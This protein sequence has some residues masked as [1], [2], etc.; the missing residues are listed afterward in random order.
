MTGSMTIRHALGL[1]AATLALVAAA[2]AT[3][4][5]QSAPA[6]SAPASGDAAAAPS[7]VSA[8]SGAETY[9]NVCAACHMPDGIGA[10]GAGA[11]PALV[12]N[13]RLI[14][15]GYPL[16]VVLKGRNGMPPLG[17]MMTDQQVADVINYVR[18]NFG[19]SYTDMVQPSEVAALR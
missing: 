12:S 1:G 18:T 5:A 11:Y 3:A 17:D 2:V 7:A 16:Y 8:Q 9:Q 15:K 19:N 6:Q 13:P 10:T 4:A 14:A